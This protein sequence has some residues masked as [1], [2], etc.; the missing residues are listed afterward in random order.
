MCTLGR[1]GATGTEACLPKAPRVLTS[2]MDGADPSPRLG[3]IVGGTRHGHPGTGAVLH[4][5]DL[6]DL[7]QPPS[8][9]IDRIPLDFL[10]H[11]FAPHPTLPCAI[12]LEKRGPGGAWVDLLKRRVER[13]IEPIPGHHFYGHGT[14]TADGTALLAIE[15]DLA[16]RAGVVSVRDPGDFTVVDRFPTHGEA[17]HD[18]QLVENGATLAVTHGGGKAG[19]STPSVT[20]VDVSTRRLLERVEVGDPR[21]NAGHLAVGRDRELVVVSAPRDG[22]PPDTSLGGVSLR[23]PAGALAYA[24]TPTALT[25]RMVGESLSVCLHE[26]SRTALTTHPFGNL[27]TFWRLDRG[28]LFAALDLRNARGATL[29]LD[30]QFFVVSFGLAGGLLLVEANPL[31]LT[32]R[33]PLGAGRF[34]GSHIYTWSPGAR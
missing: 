9:E 10:A 19:G 13:R 12:L 32:A 27:I 1:E 24:R 26:T 28:R 14:F 17:P 30:Q 5:L 29:T 4:A 21:I 18:C 11:G 31:K 8:A 33:P 2:A 25:A 6:L 16:T 7:D 15:T 20:F 22:L 3:V 34:G 23:P